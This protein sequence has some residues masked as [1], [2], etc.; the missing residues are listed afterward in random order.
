MPIELHTIQTSGKKEVPSGT[1]IGIRRGRLPATVN[2]HVQLPGQR[3]HSEFENLP[4]VDGIVQLPVK[5]VFF[6]Y[7]REDRAA[8]Q[9]LADRLWQDGFLTWLDVKELLPGD[10]WRTRIEAAVERSDHVLVFLSETR[11]K[12][13]GYVQRELRYALE[14]QQLRPLGAR[15][16]IPIRLD[17]CDPPRE[18]RHIQWLDRWEEGAYDRLKNALSD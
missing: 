8:V 5:L 15:F 16:I 7:A 13:A 1:V 4:I 3:R 11:T 14:Q 10:D 18:L 12:K 2:V 9:E 17:P 6:S